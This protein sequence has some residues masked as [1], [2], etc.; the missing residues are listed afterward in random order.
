MRA[1]LLP[2]VM[3]ALAAAS[4]S[5]QPVQLD[6]DQLD[7]VTAGGAQ[8]GVR[9]DALGLGRR[10]AAV[11]RT[12]TASFDG[13]A[14]RRAGAVGG[15]SAVGSDGARATTT[16]GSSV[17]GSSVQAFADAEAFGDGNARTRIDT[18]SIETRR[19]T[20]SLGFGVAFAVGTDGGVAFADTTVDGDAP[21]LRQRVVNRTHQTANGA[22]SV[23]NGI[24]VTRR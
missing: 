14:L 7:A 24:I 21:V 5:A 20:V 10:T 3:L 1:F 13:R 9:A 2:T 22:L 16:G 4:A 6:R 17:P 19:L 8:A 15:A 18:R 23:S 12:D 11:T